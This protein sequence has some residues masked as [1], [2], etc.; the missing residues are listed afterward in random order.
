MPNPYVNKVTVN[1]ATI[2]DLTADTVTASTLMQGYTAHDR[3]GAPITGTATGSPD[4]PTFTAN[5]TGTSITCDWTY[6]ECYAL[7]SQGDTRAILDTGGAQ[8]FVT[9]GFV[10]S[11]GDTLHYYYAQ[12][13]VPLV[14]IDYASNGTIAV[15]QPPD[16]LQTL[17]VTQNGTY[18]GFSQGVLWYEVDVSVPSGGGDTYTLTTVV[19]QQNFTPQVISGSYQTTLTYTA[20]LEDGEYYLVTF[21][22]D[23]YLCECGIFWG[24]EYMAGTIDYFWNS[25][26]SGVYPF[27]LDY[28][29]S[30]N[31]LSVGVG[32]T[33]SH[34]IKV[35]HLEFVDGPLNII[36]KSVTANGTYNASSDNADG[37]SSVTV[38][39]SGGGSP[40]LQ[41]KTATPTTSQ[42]T[43]T[44]D[45]G[46]DGLSQVTVNAIPSQY[47][48]P[49]GN[50]AITANGSNIDVAEYA[51]VSVN[52]SGS[53]MNV[54]TAQS[55]TRVASTA[56]TK[57]ASLT[58]SKAG[59]YDVYWDCFRSSTSGTN[60]SQL[61]VG[62][63]EYGNPNTTFASN[64]HAQT[65]HLTGV[66]LAANQ[67][68][69]V[70]VRSR[71]TNY[72]AYCGQLTI[73]QTA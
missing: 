68:V 59:T 3:S 17:S 22:G 16:I 62:G 33:N 27:G 18:D 12:N 44:P 28:S 67:E 47:I 66:T 38:N 42:Q 26:A 55:T 53:S 13:G 29:P 48:I 19:P 46:Y 15:V 65:N 21:D 52:V 61:Y 6:A 69:A 56:Y 20:G 7:V 57:T 64:V 2:I 25:G 14:Q 23:E 73:V 63:S 37:Y 54:Q 49:S 40:T 30:G 60:G 4:V 70:Y 8:S 1:N 31:E 45:S 11:A 50:K 10:D 41:S 36:S 39:V 9:A 43:V 51:T 72:Y 34:T 58:C 35:E 5:E 71:A 24:S 32:D